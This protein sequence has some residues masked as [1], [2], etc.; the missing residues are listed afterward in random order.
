MTGKVDSKIRERKEIRN[1]KRLELHT[2]LFKN[3]VST[4]TVVLMIYGP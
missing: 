3:S 2:Q 1:S 4:S